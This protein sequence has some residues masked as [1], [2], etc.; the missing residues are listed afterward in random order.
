MIRAAAPSEIAGAS[1]DQI[2]EYQEKGYL[3]VRGLF[4]PGEAASWSE[5]AERLLHSDLVSP[6]NIRTPFRMSS[7]EYPE[8]I[9]PVVDIS[10]LFSE[11]V[12]DSRIT[13]LVQ[14][15]FED[16]PLLF[17]DK[18]IF[19]LPGVEGYTMHQ[20]Q[21]WWQLCPPSD[22]LSVSIAIDSAS[23]A[24][25]SIALYPGYHHAML[26]PAGV[27]RNF[28]AGEI[29]QID[30]SRGELMETQPGD[31]VLFHSLTPHESGPNT[32]KAPR[33]SLYLSYSAARSGDLNKVYYEQYK[34]RVGGGS[35]SKFFK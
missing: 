28:Q 10:P 8:R 1:G 9:D 24:N 17:K 11:L 33:R 4:S 21:A 31:I 30:R 14:D 35:E 12:R 25:G 13:R 7:R 19:K 3:V 16:T 27:M 32:S 22:I 18:L 5:E 34:A 20:D 23:A 2:K 29:A 6:E 26:T 15:L